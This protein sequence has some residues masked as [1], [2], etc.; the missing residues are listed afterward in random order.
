MGYEESNFNEFVEILKQKTKE[1]YF[2]GNYY[3]VNHTKHGYKINL[4]I[5]IPGKNEKI[6]KVYKVKTNY[7]IFTNGK[8]KMNTPLGGWQK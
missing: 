8:I 5:E 3:N 2:Y 6:G 7:M 4:N 1:A